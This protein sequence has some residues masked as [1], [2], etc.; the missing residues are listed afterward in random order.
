MAKICRAVD[1]KTLKKIARS[2]RDYVT[3]HIVKARE[4]KH[5]ADF[6]NINTKVMN[7]LS[8]RDYDYSY[9]IRLV[10]NTILQEEYNERLQ[11]ELEQKK[12]NQEP[13]IRREASNGGGYWYGGE[14]NS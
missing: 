10:F 9:H 11:R 7:Y 14:N 5:L 1:I 2:G 3:S 4:K 13:Y 8:V 6:Y 12:M